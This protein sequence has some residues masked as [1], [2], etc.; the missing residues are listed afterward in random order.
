MTTVAWT[1]KMAD[2]EHNARIAGACAA[3]GWRVMPLLPATKRPAIGRWPREATADLE[4]IRDWWSHEFRHCYPG[5]LTGPESGIWVLDIDV[6][7]VNGF[8]TARDLFGAHG[9]DRLPR[10]MTVRTPSSGRHVYFAHP[11]DGRLIGNTS[12]ETGGRL[13]PGLDSRGWHGL[14]VAPMVRTGFGVYEV[15]DSSVPV[16]APRWLEDLVEKR[17][18]PATPPHVESDVDALVVAE[19]VAASLAGAS[20]GGRNHALN[21]A[22]FKLGTLG[23][24]GV[25]DEA[26][27][28]A[29]LLGACAANGLLA[30]DGEGQC[31][32]TFDSGWR[33]GLAAG[34]DQ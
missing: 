17:K 4:T 23:A 2:I 15:L 5:I 22:A 33:A 9:D 26:T 14:V 6:K 29:E 31:Q 30:D 34:E 10:T 7:V 16:T 25:L 13:G 27:A 1:N 12:G 8:A 24:L 11:T 18:R 32:A 20:A 19:T 3:L 21:V 28:W